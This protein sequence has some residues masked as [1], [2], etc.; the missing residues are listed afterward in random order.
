MIFFVVFSSLGSIDLEKGEETPGVLG[1]PNPLLAI[2]W[3]GV[4]KTW[5]SGGGP[6]LKKVSS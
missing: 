5:R 3:N 1:K 2:C 4:R 6:S